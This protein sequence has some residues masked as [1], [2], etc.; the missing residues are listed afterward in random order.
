MGLK[1]R[2]Q[3]LCKRDNISM[4]QLE[5]ELEFG[6]GYISKLGKST[7]NTTKIQKIANKFNV[8]VDYLMTGTIGNDINSP[9]PDCGLTYD[10]DY[11]EDVEYHKQ[12]HTAWEK[13]TKK[14]GKLYC[15]SI[16]NER[17]KAT[18]RKISHD[19]SLPLDKR[20]NAQIEVL[21]C[22]FSR[23]LQSNG[24]D[25]RHIPFDSYA[26]M[27]LGNKTYRKNLDDDLFNALVNKYGSKPGIDYGSIYKIPSSNFETIAAHKDGDIFTPEELNKIEEY[28]KLLIAARPKE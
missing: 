2:V 11:L 23:S 15:N 5:Q 13:A 8:T 26:S 6:K 9:C 28:K 24:Y 20:I 17:V 22:L 3:E 1:E 7:P 12:Q 19:T 18:N 16:E 25:L 21:R 14:F 10:A 27:M 4:N